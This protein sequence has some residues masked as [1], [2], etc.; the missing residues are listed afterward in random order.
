[1]KY[2]G[3]S[4]LL[5]QVENGVLSCT[6]NRPQALN[7]YTPATLEEIYAL[8]RDVAQD[9]SVR[10]VVLTGA[11]RSFCV[12]GDVKRFASGE[13]DVNAMLHAS[14]TDNAPRGFAALPQPC[15]ASINGDAIGG[16]INFA[17]ECDVILA[18]DSARFGFAYSRLG[19][20]PSAPMLTMLPLLV[21]LNRAKEYIFSGELFDAA[22][23]ERIGLVNHVYPKDQLAARTQQLAARIAESAPLSTRWAKL[24]IN[25]EVAARSNLIKSAA[26]GLMAL[27]T[28]SED[29]REGTRSFVEKR[30]P[31]FKGR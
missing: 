30:K 25:K 9:E 15:I 22:E 12:G 16:G 31:R 19:L 28:H 10:V 5:V 24:L 4:D 18:A 27:S 1:L 20:S 8:C 17:L 29:Y 23:A 26:S 7:A 13:T 2:D 6:L 11:G 21:N 3:Y 14:M